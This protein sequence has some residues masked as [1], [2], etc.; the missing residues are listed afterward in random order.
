MKIL[1]TGGAGFIGSL[2]TERL[3]K[4][5]YFVTVLDNLYYNQISLISLSHWE[6]YNFIYGDVGD[7]ELLKKLVNSHDIIIPLAAIVGTTA[8]DKDQ[9]LAIVVNEYQICN[10]VSWLSP[11]QK[12]IYP[13]TNSQYGSS[14]KVITENSPFEALSVYADTKCN[15]EKCVLDSGNGVALRLSTNFGVSPRMRLDLLVNDFVYKAVTEKCLTLFESHFTR[16]YIHV[17]DVVNTFV[18]M[19]DN[20]T[21]CNN[22]A[23]NVGLSKQN[24][25]KLELAELI[26]TFIPDLHIVQCEYKA[27]PDK[28]NYIISN[29]KLEKL[30]WKPKFRIEDGIRELIQAYKL[31]EPYNNR[32]FKNC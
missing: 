11:Y 16:S 1:I 5:G 4:L 20:Y 32:L 8:C 9:G 23:Y 29:E 21:A 22:N 12:L 18:F 2:L 17:R 26:K 10:I 6:N 27:D 31:I 14:D 13:H 24:L 7:L 15:A 30:G 3:L 25:T 28:R 19:I